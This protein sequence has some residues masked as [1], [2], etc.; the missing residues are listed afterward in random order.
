MTITHPLYASQ[1]GDR[2]SLCRGA[3]VADVYVLHEAN[4][5][6]GGQMS[7]IALGPFLAGPAGAPERQEALRLIGALME[8]AAQM[9]PATPAAPEPGAAA[10][11]P[12][13]GEA[14]R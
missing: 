3:D 12:T 5:A 7:R 14:L 4:P 8:R 6:S 1:N 13:P 10:A 2:W 11:E 9:R